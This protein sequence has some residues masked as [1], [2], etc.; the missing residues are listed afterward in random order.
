MDSGEG[1]GVGI[2]APRRMPRRLICGTAQTVER[3]TT[4]TSTTIVSSLTTLQCTERTRSY[5][6]LLVRVELITARH[7]SARC[8]L[9]SASVSE[10]RITIST[11]QSP[12]TSRRVAVGVAVGRSASGCRSRQVG[13]DRCRVLHMSHV[14]NTALM[15]PRGFVESGYT[16]VQ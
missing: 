7:T 10:S 8:S 1:S 9:F 3:T 16:H 2:G 13:E 12:A 5:S 14:A 4:S 11:Q 15:K 6:R